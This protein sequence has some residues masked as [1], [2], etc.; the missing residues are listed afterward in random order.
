MP[1]NPAYDPSWTSSHSPLKPQCT[2]SAA[3]A[4][5]AARACILSL[6]LLT[7]SPAAISVRFASGGMV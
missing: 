7:R 3:A 6:H 1:Y 5:D 4:V 2:L